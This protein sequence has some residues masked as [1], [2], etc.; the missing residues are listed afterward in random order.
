MFGRGQQR[1]SAG[2]APPVL[3]TVH[4]QPIMVADPDTFAIRRER[5]IRN[6]EGRGLQGNTGY[7]LDYDRGDPAHSFEQVLQGTSV[8]ANPYANLGIAEAVILAQTEIYD[9][10][11]N[12]AELT[13]YEANLLSRIAR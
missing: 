8:P 9:Q 13:A 2:G 10:A 1:S 11:I 7:V 6:V 5:A 3:T 12:D 4:A